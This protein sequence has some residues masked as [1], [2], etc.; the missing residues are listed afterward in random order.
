MIGFS[1]TGKRVSGARLEGHQ[2]LK[3]VAETTLQPEERFR[4]QLTHDQSQSGTVLAYC[5]RHFV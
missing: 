4:L 1:T 5:S 3:C 2:K